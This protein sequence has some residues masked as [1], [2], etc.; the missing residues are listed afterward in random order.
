MSIC[1]KLKDRQYSTILK[2]KV[3]LKACG[4]ILKTLWS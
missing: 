1:A 3:K 4:D 2:M